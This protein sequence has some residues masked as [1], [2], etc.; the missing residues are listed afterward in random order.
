MPLDLDT[1]ERTRLDRLAFRRTL[2]G[3][4]LVMAVAAVGG[5]LGLAMGWIDMGS[6]IDERLPFDSPVLAGTALAAIVALPM[7]VTAWRAWREDGRAGHT[8]ELAGVM[9]V[10]WIAVQLV[11]IRQFSFLQP[12]CVAFALALLVLAWNSGSHRQAG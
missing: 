9:L 2:A 1:A 12:V 5:G 10:G 7:A 6:T 3:L 8:G 11:V 4:A